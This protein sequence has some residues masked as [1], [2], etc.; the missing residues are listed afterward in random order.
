MAASL[1]PA[2]PK[3]REKSN[4][5]GF[6]YIAKTEFP[7][8]KNQGICR[9]QARKSRR[10]SRDCATWVKFLY[11]DEAQEV[12]AQHFYR[13]IRSAILR[14][15]SQDFPDIELFTI[16]ELARDW[17]DAGQRFFAKGGIFDSIVDYQRK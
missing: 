15:H 14:K 9:Q 1:K 4:G 12:I 17:E 6:H 10:F 13:P 16:Q 8:P 5:V 3:R 7:L 2:W 11:T